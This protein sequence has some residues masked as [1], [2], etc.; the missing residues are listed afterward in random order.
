[1]LTPF[2]EIMIWVSFG[3]IGVLSILL[4]VL[5]YGTIKE[6]LTIRKIE[7]LMFEMEL[8][9]KAYVHMKELEEKRKGR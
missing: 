5:I 4:F 7:K 9:K 1:M 6:I 8:E 3:I 2:E